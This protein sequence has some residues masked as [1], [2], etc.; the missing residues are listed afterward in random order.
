MRANCGV[1]MD[2]RKVIM[3]AEFEYGPLSAI[4]ANAGIPSNGGV[5]VPNDEWQRIY[6]VNVMQ[7]VYIA[8]HWLPYVQE[9]GKGSLLITASAAGLLTQIGSMPYSVTKHAAVSV[10]E[11]MHIT[12]KPLGLH[13]SCLCPQAVKTG[14]VPE[15]GAV[16][17]VDGVLE[18]AAVARES[19]VRSA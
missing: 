10:A 4:I 18:P 11:W 1:E 3:T 6:Q 16:A 13:V 14:M 5:E 8:R 2:L 12:Y 17:G 7:H 9:R 15:G 19:L